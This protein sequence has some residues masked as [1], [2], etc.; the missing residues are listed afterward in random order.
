MNKVCLIFLVVLGMS[1]TDVL[2]QQEE[3]ISLQETVLMMKKKKILLDYLNLT[4][5]EKAAFWPL[6]DDY[7]KQIRALEEE[8]IKLLMLCSRSAISE[9]DLDHYSKRLLLNDLLL[10]KVRKQYYQKFKNAVSP[11][12]AAQFMQ[13]DDSFRMMQRYEAQ[14]PKTNT[15]F[16]ASVAGGVPVLKN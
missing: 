13:F 14:Q 12:R 3:D 11:A 15:E 2:G 5:A 16:Q 1:T 10:A 4:E 6:Y 8:S 9:K 7:Y